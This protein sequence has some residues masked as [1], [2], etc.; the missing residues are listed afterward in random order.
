MRSILSALLFGA[1]VL[2]APAAVVVPT[3][4][5]AVECTPGIGDGYNR[6]G[7]YCDA[8]RGTGSLSGPV[9][10]GPACVLVFSL[11]STAKHGVRILVADTEDDAIP[12]DEY[13]PEPYCGRP[14]H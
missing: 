12:P 5:T 14:P 8:A 11:L 13:Q 10:P 4:A 9:T 7:G 6:P 3:A 1:S 2:V